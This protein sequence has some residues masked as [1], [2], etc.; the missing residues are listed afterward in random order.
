MHIFASASQNCNEVVAKLG[1]LHQKV[2]KIFTQI[3]VEDSVHDSKS[4]FKTLSRQWQS[5]TNSNEA[6]VLF[7]VKYLQVSQ[8]TAKV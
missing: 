7:H 3:I 8:R 6:N 5:T 1:K 2:Y 4:I